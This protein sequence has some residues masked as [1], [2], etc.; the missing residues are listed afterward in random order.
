VKTTFGNL[1]EEVEIDEPRAR[2]LVSSLAREEGVSG[3]EVTLVFVDDAYIRE[4]KGRYLGVRRATDVLAFPLAE[5]SREEAQ[6]ETKGGGRRRSRNVGAA[7]GGP[8]PENLLGEVY[9][10]TQRAIDQ[11]RCNHVGLSEEIARLIVHGLL[12]LFGYRDDSSSSRREMIRR[13]ESFLRE[14]KGTASA[15]AK[16]VKDRRKDKS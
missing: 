10:S 12:H 14:H 6:G 4:L 3:R 9:I 16:R 11:A 13:Q 5:D 7:S 2:T 8:P 1:Q 15:V